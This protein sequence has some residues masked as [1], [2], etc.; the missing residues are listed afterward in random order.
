LY[1]R[2]R[3]RFKNQEALFSD[4]LLTPKREGES[5]GAGKTLKKT[6]SRHPP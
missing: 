4:G 1:F 5:V 6:V 3:E 2:I